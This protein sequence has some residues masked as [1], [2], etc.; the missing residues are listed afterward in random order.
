MI[1]IIKASKHHFHEEDWLKTYWHFTF[2]D[3]Y[4]PKNMGI[5]TLRVFNDDVI[6]PG[7][8]FGFHPH[9]NMEIVTYVIE[10][11]LKHRDN[12]GNE[13]VIM[14]GE[15]Q[16]M[17]AGTGI[18]HSEYN[19][20]PTKDLKLLQMWVMPERNGLKP[21]W[22]QKRFSKEERT[23]NLRNIISP[24]N[25]KREGSLGIHQDA[26]FYVSRIV[27][28]EIVHS[29]KA[30][31]A[32]LFVIEGKIEVNGKIMETKDAIKIADE[33]VIKITPLNDSEIILID[34]GRHLLGHF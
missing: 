9:A 24:I 34:M 12:L 22:E 7:K 26:H 16:R 15:V 33:T 17:T 14:P 20:S 30:R 23:D 29:L 19:N 8:G 10:G 6:R 28:K 18:I 32:Y 27:K 25:S 21:S 31:I 5:G 2:A 11:E 3:Y 4:D 1:D 13:G